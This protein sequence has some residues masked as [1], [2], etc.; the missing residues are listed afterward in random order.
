M[1]K[2]SKQPEAKELLLAS[3]D[4]AFADAGESEKRWQEWEKEQRLT[5]ISIQLPEQEYQILQRLA[6]EQK[7]SAPQLVQSLV[8]NVLS[9]LLISRR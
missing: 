4:E 2:P 3:V 1:T 5:S 8:H 7:K 9:A 6:V